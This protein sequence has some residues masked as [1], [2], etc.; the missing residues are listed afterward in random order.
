MPKKGMESMTQVEGKEVVDLTLTNKEI[1]D[2]YSKKI[3]KPKVAARKLAEVGM[4]KIEN[5]VGGYESVDNVPTRILASE[6]LRKIK[7]V[8]PNFEVGVNFDISKLNKEDALAYIAYYQDINGLKVDGILGKNTYGMAAKENKVRVARV[9]EKSKNQAQAGVDIE[10]LD[11]QIDKEMKEMGLVK[12]ESIGRT[13]TIGDIPK[14]RLVEYTE[15]YG[16]SLPKLKE[17]SPARLKVEIKKLENRRKTA[18]KKEALKKMKN[19]LMVKADGAVPAVSEKA[20]KD[21]VVVNQLLDMS[22]KYEKE[23]NAGH[24]DLLDMALVL[25][26][27][28]PNELIS[29]E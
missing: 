21:L 2:K 13:L 19:D 23:L 16:A 15:K 22:K 17:L 25:G 29:V 5:G 14:L 1:V 9:L 10:E 7:L 20:K 12:P 8:N 6:I 11:A 26:Y 27:K 4:M 28:V 3:T 24:V 18:R